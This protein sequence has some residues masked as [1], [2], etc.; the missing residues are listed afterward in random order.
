MLVWGSPLENQLY[1]GLRSS[2]R[3]SRGH[4]SPIHLET[5]PPLLTAVSQKSH[6]NRTALGAGWDLAFKPHFPAVWPWTSGLTSLDLG[7]WVREQGAVQKG[8]HPD[9]PRRRKVSAL[10]RPAS[11]ESVTDALHPWLTGPGRSFQRY[12]GIVL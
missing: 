11:A 8:L 2:S 6:P 12:V 7:R 4:G 3:P 10:L 9:W 1:S 5:N